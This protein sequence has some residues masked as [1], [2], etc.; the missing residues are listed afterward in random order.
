MV[1]MAIILVLLIPLALESLV[2]TFVV[3]TMLFNWAR[4]KQ[5]ALS[6]LHLLMVIVFFTTLL[7]RI[8]TQ[9]TTILQMNHSTLQFLIPLFLPYPYGMLYL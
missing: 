4:N 8:I 2:H 5:I 9:Q 6:A 3:T 7:L 1:A